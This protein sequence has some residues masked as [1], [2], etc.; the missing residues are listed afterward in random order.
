MGLLALAFIAILF[1]ALIHPLRMMGLIIRFFVGLFLLMI[2][3]AVLG[4]GSH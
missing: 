2:V 4:S 1:Y 3:L